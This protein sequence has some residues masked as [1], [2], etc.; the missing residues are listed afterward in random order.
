MPTYSYQLFNDIKEDKLSVSAC[1]GMF[2]SFRNWVENSNG[3]T[4]TKANWLKFIKKDKFPSRMTEAYSMAFI[5][6]ED[7]YE[8]A[9]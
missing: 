3:F 6:S 9:S 5:P 2:Y 8:V 7:E 1:L 4:L